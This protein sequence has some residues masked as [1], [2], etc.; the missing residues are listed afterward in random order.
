MQV[1]GMFHSLA[2]I[3]PLCGMMCT[4]E[5]PTL[6]RRCSVGDAFQRKVAFLAVIA[7]ITYSPC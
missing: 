6:S 7:F 5:D 2:P 1:L 4:W 3:V